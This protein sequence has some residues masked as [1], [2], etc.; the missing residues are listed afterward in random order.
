LS[1]FLTE[2]WEEEAI[3][4][5]ISPRSFFELKD[6]QI[7]SKQAEKT[8]RNDFL[9][10]GTGQSSIIQSFREEPDGNFVLRLKKPVVRFLER[11]RERLRERPRER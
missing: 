1:R 3:P 11:M 4:Q 2:Y 8:F 7:S 9:G 10:L 6:L 5:E